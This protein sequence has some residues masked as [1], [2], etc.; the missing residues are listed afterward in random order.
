MNDRSRGATRA[1]GTGDASTA[2]GPR[3][4]DVEHNDEFMERMA[5]TVK[6][7]KAGWPVGAQ[8]PAFDA[9][10]EFQERRTTQVSGPFLRRSSDEP[11]ERILW[12]PWTHGLI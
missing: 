10:G 5:A 12:Q 3:E 6:A 8:P 7:L 9:D 11:I 1:R 2:G 4:S